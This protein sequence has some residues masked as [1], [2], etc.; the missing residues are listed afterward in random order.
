MRIQLPSPET[1]TMQ[2]AL[3]QHVAMRVGRY[4]FSQQSIL[5]DVSLLGVLTLEHIECGMFQRSGHLLGFQVPRRTP[6]LL[7]V[8]SRGHYC[9][10]A[11]HA[12]NK[13]GCMILPP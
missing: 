2:T 9:Y 5:R 6:Y 4:L 8:S 3:Q 7:L 13:M 1:R 10:C 12:L 11:T